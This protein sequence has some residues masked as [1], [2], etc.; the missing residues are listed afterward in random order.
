MIVAKAANMDLVVFAN[1]GDGDWFEMDQS[2]V[3][4]IAD[5][6]FFL[7]IPKHKEI[8]LKWLNGSDVQCKLEN[9]SKWIKVA[10]YL[11]MPKWRKEGF[12]NSP[13]DY[14]YRI[15]PKK[16]KRWIGYCASTNQTF[17]RSQDSKELAGDYAARS[18]NYNMSDWQLIE[19]EVEV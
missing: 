17:P 5:F 14:V 3:P 12:F 10:P 13:Y 4:T 2:E 8:C 6:D 11:E 1:S 16:E 18:Y 19:I 15:K 9:E 7:C